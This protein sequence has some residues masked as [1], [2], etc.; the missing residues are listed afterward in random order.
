MTQILLCYFLLAFRTQRFE[1]T[2]R[3]S[4]TPLPPNT[5]EYLSFADISLEFG[6]KSIEFLVLIFQCDLFFFSFIFVRSVFIR[7]LFDVFFFIVNS[8]KHNTK[9]IHTDNILA[10][11]K[12]N[13]FDEKKNHWFPFY[14]KI[15]WSR[16]KWN[17]ILVNCR[18][19]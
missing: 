13:I 9:K 5:I 12:C 1:M 11:K 14:S 15:G 19:I 4:V 3:V 10:G 7:L 18:Y 8:N 16:L 6:W 2:M 17:S